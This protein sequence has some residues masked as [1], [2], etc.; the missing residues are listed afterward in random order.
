MVQRNVAKR[1]GK[2]DMD[3]KDAIKDGCE[4]GWHSGPLKL[5]KSKRQGRTCL[6]IIPL[7]G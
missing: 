3:R 5:G 7:E 2:R 6:R 1:V 4:V